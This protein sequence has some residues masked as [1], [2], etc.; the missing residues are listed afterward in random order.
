[1]LNKWKANI[2][3]FAEGFYC[4]TGSKLNTFQFR[5]SSTANTTSV[6]SLSSNFS[7]LPRHYVR[8]LSAGLEHLSRGL[9]KCLSVR[10]IAF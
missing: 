1:M 5:V 7:I 8:S 6:V 4:R 9:G 10:L 3:Q 2:V